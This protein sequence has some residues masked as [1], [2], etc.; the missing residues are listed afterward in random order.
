[1][2]LKLKHMQSQKNKKKNKCIIAIRD[3]FVEAKIP[4]HD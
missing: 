4:P 3:P 1:M 2:S